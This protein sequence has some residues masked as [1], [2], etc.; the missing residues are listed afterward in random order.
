MQFDRQKQVLSDGK[1]DLDHGYAKLLKL[2]TIKVEFP[3][4][5]QIFNI[6]V[7]FVAS[8]SPRNT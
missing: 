6:M 2:V 3:L 1:K 7:S 5:R 8:K 4:I